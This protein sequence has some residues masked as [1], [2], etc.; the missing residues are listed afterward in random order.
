MNRYAGSMKE[1]RADNYS[2][3][4]AARDNGINKALMHDLDARFEN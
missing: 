4:Q 2:S 3:G 1:L